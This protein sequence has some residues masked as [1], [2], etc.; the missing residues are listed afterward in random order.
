MGIK[1]IRSFS[2]SSSIQSPKFEND[3]KKVNELFQIRFIA[4]H[5]KVDTLYDSGS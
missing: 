4:I 1:G 3:D 2:S 5:T